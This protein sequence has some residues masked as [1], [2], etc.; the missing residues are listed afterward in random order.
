VSTAKVSDQVKQIRSSNSVS[1]HRFFN[2]IAAGV[3]KHLEQQVPGLKL[4][5]AAGSVTKNGG[6]TVLTGQIIVQDAD[7]KKSTEDKVRQVMDDL[8]NPADLLSSVK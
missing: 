5:Q 3:Q 4:V 8:K 2:M 7:E 1:N 6:T